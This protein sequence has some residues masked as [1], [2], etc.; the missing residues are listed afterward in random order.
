MRFD[1]YF[2]AFL[3]KNTFQR[4][5]ISV[6]EY[7]LQEND[8]VNRSL[9]L[10][11]SRFTE[12]T[13][14]RLRN[15]RIAEAKC[16]RLAL[17]VMDGRRVE[18]NA[19]VDDS[20]S[21]EDIYE[22]YRCWKTLESYQC[23]LISALRTDADTEACRR[24]EEMENFCLQA[25][26]AEHFNVERLDR[27]ITWRQVSN[28]DNIR[29]FVRDFFRRPDGVRAKSALN[30]MIVF[31]GHGSPGGFC[32]GSQCMPLDEIILFVK[33][34][35]RQSWLE[36]PEELPVKVEIIFGQ[37]YAHLHGRGVLSDRFTV[38]TLTTH[39]DPYT[40]SSES[41]AGTFVNEELE[42]YA[43]GTLRQNA[44][45]METWRQSDVDNFVDLS[46]AQRSRSA[47][48]NQQATTPT[49]KQ[50]V[51]LIVLFSCVVLT[52]SLCMRMIHIFIVP[53]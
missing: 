19:N 24:K 28:D 51:V 38:T 39:D 14:M 21:T 32:V 23:L 20:P 4:V 16:E 33:E 2:D 45:N 3:S 46:A 27:T 13:M 22:Y 47:S 36:R 1:V 29:H 12:R 44:M 9:A 26:P 49:S 30:T 31:F 52:V 18:I 42:N 8:D 43:E 6:A 50:S 7:K 11:R 15:M 41:V 40:T 5:A 10:I 53:A 48:E 25:F 37:C 34:E 35:W 17:I